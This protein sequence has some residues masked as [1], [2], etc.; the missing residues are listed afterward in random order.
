MFVRSSKSHTRS[1]RMGSFGCGANTG[2]GGISNK[3]NR[4]RRTLKSKTPPFTI[5][6]MGHPAK[7]DSAL[8]KASRTES[9]NTGVVTRYGAAA[10]V[11]SRSRERRQKGTKDGR[12]LIF[13]RS[14]PYLGSHIAEYT[15]YRLP[16]HVNFPNPPRLGLFGS[17]IGEPV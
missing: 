3:S 16:E 7:Q 6:R 9:P 17:E 1:I 15:A 4:N 11:L 10:M 5:R 8:E 14:V 12:P 2:F 13:L